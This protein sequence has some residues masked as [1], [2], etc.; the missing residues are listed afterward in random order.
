MTYS[1]TRAE[2]ASGNKALVGLRRAVRLQFA[3]MAHGIMGRELP[4]SLTK[5]ASQLPNDNAVAVVYAAHQQGRKYASRM[6]DLDMAMLGVPAEARTNIRMANVVDA[7]S[8]IDTGYARAAG[9]VAREIYAQQANVM[10][11]RYEKL[12]GARE[13]A[14]GF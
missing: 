13:A 2:L 14:I 3:A 11:Q 6:G 1:S 9:S 10:R 8:A 7:F 5:W 12:L 4:V